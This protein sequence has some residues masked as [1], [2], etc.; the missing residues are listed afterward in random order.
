MIEKLVR[1]RLDDLKRA[2]NNTDVFVL[3]CRAKKLMFT[4]IDSTAR[5]IVKKMI[6]NREARL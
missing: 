4:Q 6:P 5:E 1:E 2:Y 3:A